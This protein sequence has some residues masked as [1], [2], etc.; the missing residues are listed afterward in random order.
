MKLF[1]HFSAKNVHLQEMPFRSELVMQAYILENE[2]VLEVDDGGGAE[3]IDY[4]LPLE[5]GRESKNTDGRIDLLVSYGNTKVGVVELKKGKLVKNNYDQLADYFKAK[6]KIYSD[7]F[8]LSEKE[9]E[10]VGVLVGG[11]IEDSFSNEL[12]KGKLLIQGNIP[13]VA[14]TLKRFKDENGQ[15]YILT[16]SH[17]SNKYKKD[18]SR[19]EFNG[20]SYRKNRLALAF[21]QQFVV[22]HYE[23]SLAD[24][25]EI[26]PK[27][28]YG[29]K[30]VVLAAVVARKQSETPNSKGRKA[31]YYFV[32]DDEIILLHDGKSVAV[33]DWWNKDN[34]QNILKLAKKF[35][36]KIEKLDD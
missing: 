18:N 22:D 23:K 2:N 16:E 8:E 14:I 19:Y 35:G 15:M 13:V 27:K 20:N 7:N 30:E 9:R 4:E 6:D 25:Q 26:F 32:K 34:I 24:F 10:W 36:Y 33:L 31:R 17:A 3:I 12:K 28:S 21:I 11:D 1:T 29:G 5:K